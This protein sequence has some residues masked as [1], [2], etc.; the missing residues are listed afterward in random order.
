MRTQRRCLS[1]KRVLFPHIWIVHVFIFVL[2]LG[3]VLSIP[4]NNSALLSS[5]L[6]PEEVG[7]SE[8]AQTS[9]VQHFE[10]VCRNDP[11]WADKMQATKRHYNILQRLHPDVSTS[12]SHLHSNHSILW[13]GG[14]P[15]VGKS[16]V[17][18]RFQQYGFTV[19]DAEDNWAKGSLGRLIRATDHAR[20]SSIS[21]VFGACSEEF[22]LHAPKG[23]IPILLLPS[24]S[25]YAERW[26]ARSPNDSQ[27]HS[28]KGA[29]WVAKNRRVVTIRQLQAECVDQTLMRIC[30]ST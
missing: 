3:D 17:T 29:E 27:R 20:K 28:L 26:K 2:F 9:E 18:S 23:V 22:L 4:G 1:Q 7:R 12:C 24:P 21:V 6:L 8:G 25:V 14:P 11:F 30:M 5:L 16:T 19:L 13:I 15:G 10:H